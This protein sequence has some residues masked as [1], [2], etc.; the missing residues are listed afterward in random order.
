MLDK[1]QR[2]GGGDGYVD[3]STGDGEDGKR[4]AAPFLIAA[5]Q[6]A[7]GPSI[8][9]ARTFLLDFMRP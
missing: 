9:G 2:G 4:L 1:P 5:C 8:Q 7:S 3:P 6:E